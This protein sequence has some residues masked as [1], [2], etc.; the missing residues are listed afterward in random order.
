MEKIIIP[1]GDSSHFND[2]NSAEKVFRKKEDPQE[3]AVLFGKAIDDLD[4]ALF[5]KAPNGSTF[6]D[7]TDEDKVLIQNTKV[8]AAY[9]VLAIDKELDILKYV[10][11]DAKEKNKVAEKLEEIKAE[12]MK[13][14]DKNLDPISSLAIDDIEFLRQALNKRF[15]NSLKEINELSE[16]ALAN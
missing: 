1:A 12:I 9:V 13:A 5:H 2:I 4:I 16:K 6:K 10:L 14:R 7:A 8:D 15:E 11:M 3:L